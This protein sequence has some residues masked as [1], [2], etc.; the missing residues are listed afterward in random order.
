MDWVRAAN[1]G[2]AQLTDIDFFQSP[3]GQR[4]FVGRSSTT[5]NPQAG[6]QFYVLNTRQLY[7]CD[8]G[9]GVLFNNMQIPSG[10]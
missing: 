5:G 8:P 2:W 3:E 9:C 1:F 4:I 10:Q 7:S 6:N